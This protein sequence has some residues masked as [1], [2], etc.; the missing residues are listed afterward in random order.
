MRL[1]DTVLYLTSPS[2]LGS[3]YRTKVQLTLL[4]NFKRYW[5]SYCLICSSLWSQNLG[6]SLLGYSLFLF[7]G[8]NHFTS[9]L[10]FLVK[11]LFFKFSTFTLM[12][13]VC[14]SVTEFQNFKNSVLRHLILFGWVTVWH[15]Q[16]CLE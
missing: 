8:F 9:R 15:T 10:R 13:Q 6:C 4:V 16:A 7:S 12:S 3:I 11:G 1:W 14:K 5:D 2:L